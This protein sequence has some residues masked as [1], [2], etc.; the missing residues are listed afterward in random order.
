VFVC[1]KCSQT[2]RTAEITAAPI[3]SCNNTIRLQYFDTAT[4]FVSEGVRL[5]VVVGFAF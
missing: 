3:S 2:G 5:C 1:D 4:G